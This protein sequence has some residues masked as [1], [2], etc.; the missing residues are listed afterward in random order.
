[1]VVDEHVSD[2]LGLGFDENKRLRR[3]RDAGSRERRQKGQSRKENDKRF[4]SAPS[5][6]A[7]QLF[8][9]TVD[10]YL[11]RSLTLCLFRAGIRLRSFHIFIFCCKK[12]E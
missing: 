1:M 3:M 10:L 5:S 6:T 2:D 12:C 8:N 7:L 4:K 11:S 9:G